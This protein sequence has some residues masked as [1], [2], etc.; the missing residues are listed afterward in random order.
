MTPVRLGKAATLLA[1]IA[2]LIST[3]GDEVA[4]VALALRGADRT[5]LASVVSAQMLAGLV[6]GI[7]LGGP[8]GRIVDRFRLDVVLG[9]TLALE[10]AIAAAAAAFADGPVLLISTML[11][12]GALGAV[13]QTCVMALVPRLF[14]A[15]DAQLK[16]NGIMESTRN[17][18]YIV[19]PLLVGLLTAH[20][21][22]GLALAVDAGTFAFALLS[23]P[24]IT[25]WLALRSSGPPAAADAPSSPAGRPAEEPA[26]K[27]AQKSAQGSGKESA[28]P[29]A[30]TKSGAGDTADAAA[31]A[32]TARTPD[33][34]EAPEPAA[35]AKGGLR[36]GLALLWTGSQRRAVLGTIVL[37]VAS[38][39]VVNVLMPFFAREIPGGTAS[40]GTLLATWSVGLV[41]GPF[42]L[43]GRIGARPTAV[44]A[45]GASAIIGL[46]H[47][48]TAAYL[49]LPA[50]LAA[51]LCGGMANAVQNVTLR[52]HVMA[53]CP[54]EVR[55][56]VGAAY[57]A[58]LQS[59]VAVGFAL[60]G[61]APAHWA[62]W[63]I[64]TGGAVAFVVGTLGWLRARALVPAEPPAAPPA[65]E[66]VTVPPARVSEEQAS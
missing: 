50:M 11:F 13:A 47:L 12:L 57:G 45:V 17:G 66:A 60:A 41:V 26:Q 31:S 39:S 64:L 61:F 44:L 20:G 29:A 5:G 2:L 49:F 42:V 35:P 52:T 36:F 30:L 59:S 23:I 8:I 58:T 51:S 48:L 55:G 3:I 46:C 6:P 27:S 65:A 38:T 37:T 56:R 16:V 40:Y 43:R 22:T 1:V 4:L 15:S 62:R 14:P 10:C 32:D 18:G 21:G 54:Q 24:V 53:D 9:V 33:T 19:G 63:G 7:A 34:T 28:K 25:Q